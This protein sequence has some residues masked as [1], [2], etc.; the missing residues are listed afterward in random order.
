MV[1]ADDRVADQTKALG[2]ILVS[3]GAM[4]LWNANVQYHPVLLAAM[5]RGAQRVLDVG[6]GDGILTAE[7]IQA[8]V[9]YVI[10][11]DL[12]AGVLDRAKAR[13]ADKAIEWVHGDVFAVPLERGSFDAV[14]SVAT[15]HHLNAAEGLVRFADL[16]RPG[17]VVAVLGLAAHQWWDLPHAALAHGARTVLGL[18][19]GQ[20]AHSA[21]MAWPPPETYREMKRI[22]NRVLPG[23]RYQRHLLGRYS[24]LWT[25]PV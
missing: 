1:L 21:P 19:H 9:P 20:W 12:D 8:G 2:L 3:M 14:V 16:V 6:C 17:G 23:V 15:L 24:L 25:K 5:P 11:L 4:R 13:H 18:V 7:L 22:S 10:G